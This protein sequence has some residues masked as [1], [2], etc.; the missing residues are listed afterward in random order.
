M[1]NSVLTILLASAFS[2][3]DDC[4]IGTDGGNVFVEYDKEIEMLREEVVVDMFRDS[5]IVQ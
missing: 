1:K 4:S 2:R 5:A 3:A